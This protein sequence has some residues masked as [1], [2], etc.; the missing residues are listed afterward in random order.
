MAISIDLEDWRRALADRQIADDAQRRF[1]QHRFTM[2]EHERR[3]A[4]DSV[5]F[6]AEEIE[7]RLRPLRAAAESRR[8]LLEQRLSELVTQRDH[9]QSQAASGQGSPVRINQMNRTLQARISAC[10]SQINAL[11]KL[12]DAQ[13][14][15]DISA[16]GEEEVAFFA[17]PIDVP[18]WTGPAATALPRTMAIAG[19]VG[20]IASFLPWFTAPGSLRMGTLLSGVAGDATPVAGLVLGYVGI[21]LPLLVAGIASSTLRNRPWM[22]I[23]ASFAVAFVWIGMCYVRI[24]SNVPWWSISETIGAMRVGAWLYAAAAC[25]GLTAACYYAQGEGNTV[26]RSLR[27]AMWLVAL[28]AVPGLAAAG[29][30]AIRPGPPAVAVDVTPVADQLDLLSLSITNNGNE[31]IDVS[32]PWSKETHYGVRLEVK[33]PDS[34]SFRRVDE[35]ADCWRMPSDTE[36]ALNRLA[37][38]PSVGET[39]WFDVACIRALGYEPERLRFSLADADGR[40]V[41]AYQALLAQ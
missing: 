9:V 28:F 2:G 19:I 12:L 10:G 39:V 13:A 7:T 27:T 8:R 33:L 11:A 15:E 5:R 25:I 16:L 1:E 34:D 24:T 6:Q 30:L 37:I 38:A 4:A 32:L 29:L 40:T 23:A 26:Q 22:T 35:T 17:Q 31:A 21:A 3:A 14:P 41:K 18:V 36:R 20:L